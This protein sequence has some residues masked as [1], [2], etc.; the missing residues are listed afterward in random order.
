MCLH[1]CVWAL[2]QTEPNWS[3]P[4]YLS[5][6]LYYPKPHPSKKHQVAFHSTG[7]YTM[8]TPLKQEKWVNVFK[9]IL[10]SFFVGLNKPGDVD[11]KLIIPFFDRLFCCLPKS[12]RSKLWCGVRHD[13]EQ[14]EI[15]LDDMESDVCTNMLK[16]QS[17]IQLFNSPKEHVMHL[18][19]HNFIK[20]MW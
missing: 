14:D 18:P 16:C 4:W 12:L 10:I 19:P 15:S 7:I 20:F 2:G 17:E 9:K 11:P 8:R 6:L 13:E 1:T 3:K 5:S